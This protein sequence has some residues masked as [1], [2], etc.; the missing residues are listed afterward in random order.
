MKVVFCTPS[1]KRPADAF[2]E[3]M[4]ASIPLIKDAGW[5]EGMAQELNCPYISHARA[6]MTRKALDADADVIV[7]LDYDLSWEPDALLK[8]I[9]TDDDVVAATYR[10]KKDDEEYMG[11]LITGPEYAP[12]VR[13]DG[14]IRADWVPAGFL[15]VTREA[16]RKIMKTY[17]ELLYGA[18]D[19]YS[20][21]LFNHGAYQGIWY[22]EDYAFSRRW[23]DAG[24][25]IWIMPDMNITHHNIDTGDAYEGNF[26]NFLRRQP[27]GDLHNG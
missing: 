7:Y 9:S 3:S 13:E 19:N 5:D 27:G 15:K 25:M 22:G 24:G 23:N 2:L 8:L 11:T 10:F 18:P 14:L 17:P 1:M 20:V 26:H 4:E 21:D 6:K 16:I 12:I